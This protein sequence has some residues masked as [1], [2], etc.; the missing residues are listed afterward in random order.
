MGENSYNYKSNESLSTLDENAWSYWYQTA[1]EL[2]KE[3]KELKA[4]LET[5]IKALD[6]IVDKYFDLQPEKRLYENIKESNVSLIA[7]QA[8]KEIKEL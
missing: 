6:S 1:N 8:L 3:N 7:R 4:K 5:A 2:K